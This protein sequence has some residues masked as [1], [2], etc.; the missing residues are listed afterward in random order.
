MPNYQT[1]LVG[2]AL[3]FSVALVIAA[4]I[5]QPSVLT[6]AEWFLFALAGSFFPDVDIKSKGQKYFY[7][8]IFLLLIVLAITQRFVPLAIISIIA[9]IPLLT[10]HRGLLHRTWFI[11]AAPL[12]TWHIL[13]S[14]FPTINQCLLLDML[15]FIVG[16][17]SHLWLDMGWRKML[18]I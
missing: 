11:I 2:G 1:H 16:A 4:P 10:K 6:A 3:S 15:F 5:Y 9:T 13:A 8:M 12:L 17:L 18:R 14:Q 7:W